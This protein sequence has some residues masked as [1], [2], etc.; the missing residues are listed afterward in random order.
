[1]V[2][3]AEK[4]P[5]VRVSQR[6]TIDADCAK[7]LTDGFTPWRLRR[8]D[9]PPRTNNPLCIPAFP[10]GPF[11]QHI[12][13]SEEVSKTTLVRSVLDPAMRRLHK[14]SLLTGHITFILSGAQ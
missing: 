2:E 14:I 11:G 7:H 10:F 4:Y 5:L 12:G 3:V 8:F 9:P 13:V 1:M 6:A